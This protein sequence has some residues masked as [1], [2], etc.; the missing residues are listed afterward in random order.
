LQ[1]SRFYKN[2]DSWSRFGPK[3]PENLGLVFANPIHIKYGLIKNI[4]NRRI[5][6]ITGSKGIRQLQDYSYSVY[7]QKALTCEFKITGKE[8]ATGRAISISSNKVVMAVNETKFLSLD[9][10]LLL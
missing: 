8:T 9:V 3:N 10:S 2:R 5:L 1:K 6:A 7:S 4:F